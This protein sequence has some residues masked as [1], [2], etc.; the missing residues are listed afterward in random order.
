MAARRFSSLFARIAVAG[1]G[2]A[3]WVVAAAPA[4]AQRGAAEPPSA[5]ASAPTPAGQTVEIVGGRETATDQRRHSTAAKIVVGRDEIDRYGDASI[6]DVLK[7]LPGVT[8]PGAGGRRGAPRMRGLGG[9][10]TQLLID[11]QR[12]PRGFDL[13]SLTPEQVERI[14]ILRAPTAETGARAIA[15]TINIVLREGRARLRLND[16]K[17][18]VAAENGR[19]SPSLNWTRSDTAGALAYTASAALFRRRTVDEATM[20]TDI[21][22][23]D[24]GTLLE[25]HRR[26]SASSSVR[27]GVSL[28]SRLTWPLEGG[29]S[30]TLSPS[31]FHSAA[32]G[33][34][35]YT[36]EPTL[37]RPP[38]SPLH[39]AG[40][41]AT[42]SR[43]THAR[44]GWQWRDRLGDTRVEFGGHG[45]VWRA[46]SDGERSETVEG[47]LL[48]RWRDTSA[49]R[50]RTLNLALKTTTN[51]G[52]DGDDATADGDRG[53]HTIVA[54]AD[55][56]TTTRRETR[57]TEP[58]VLVDYG[59]HLQ[60]RSL[61]LAAWAQDEWSIGT[62]WA[63]HAGL[64]WESIATR[65][66]TGVVDTAIGVDPRPTNDSRVVTPL[67]HAVYRPDPRSRD[68]LRVSLTRSYRSPDLANLIARPV[69]ARDW[70]TGGPNLPTAPDRVG[71]PALRPEV[72]I[73]V[74]VA[75]ERYL[76]NGGVLSANVYQRR[77][78]DLIRGV[79]TLETVPWSPVPRWVRRPANIGGATVRGV[80][81]EAKFRL[82]ALV[83]GASDVELRANAAFNDSRV[84]AVPG[85]DN[86]LD[87]QA[88]ASAN[89]GADWRIAGTRWKVGGN[90]AWTPATTTRLDTDQ[91]VAVSA[92]RL[93]DAYALWTLA[94]GRAL[95]LTASN[96]APEDAVTTTTVT[97][98]GLADGRERTTVHSTS[99]TATNWQLR[100]ELRL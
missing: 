2:V 71:N 83:A 29:G 23:A 57:T 1:S 13:D 65:G 45:G 5:A 99:P 44:F 54:G 91:V 33:K 58:E 93:W 8:T 42:D 61:R 12:A 85:P 55:V 27:D 52:G 15:G 38:T 78:D 25:G 40:F 39:D 76:P 70:P 3:A 87:Q 28:S 49:T 37:V 36:I 30:F 10:Y 92:R 67:L 63:V 46:D 50:E 32:T 100:L 4:L 98:A 66:D 34:D 16:L 96:L 22:D 69:L 59:D 14:E 60:A 97:A 26:S 56:E 74:D 81:L 68:Q 62:R 19:W 82:D 73:G 51:V 94:P 31:T 84:D 6:A 41:G 53:L 64:R 24:D 88:R 21:V 35:R 86:R 75:V 20:L 48:R 80:E 43:Y 77:V 17:L 9:G 89:V 47:D 18:G 7:R 79:T 11:G 72:A 90:V 95:R